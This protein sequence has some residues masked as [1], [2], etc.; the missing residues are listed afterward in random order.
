MPRK[1]KSLFDRRRLRQARLAEGLSQSEVASRLRVSQALVSFWEN[2][3]S[4]PNDVNIKRL[5]RLLGNLSGGGGSEND[6][7]VADNLGAFGAW[8]RRTRERADMSVAELA[9][10]AKVTPAAVYNDVVAKRE[11]RRQG[12]GRA[13]I[14]ALLAKAKAEG[15]VHVDLTSAPG[16]TEAQ[17]LYQSC[18]FHVRDTNAFRLK[19]GDA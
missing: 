12:V 11:W 19:L 8:L 15:C 7:L 1:K 13:I 6:D 9:A 16:R 3:S 10:A 17:H 4:V 2:G 14:N 18:G 5:S